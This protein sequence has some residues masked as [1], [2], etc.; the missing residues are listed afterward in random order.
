MDRSGGRS[1]R[2]QQEIQEERL[3]KLAQNGKKKGRRGLGRVFPHY[4]SPKTA[5]RGKGYRQRRKNTVAMSGR[6][7]ESVWECGWTCRG[8]SKQTSPSLWEVVVLPFG[9]ID[10]LGP[11]RPLL[12]SHPPPPMHDPELILDAPSNT[13]SIKEYGQRGHPGSKKN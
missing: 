6:A 11:L 13:Y 9:T 10:T 12:S 4:R 7:R 5:G 3:Q 2:Q 8:L 1:S